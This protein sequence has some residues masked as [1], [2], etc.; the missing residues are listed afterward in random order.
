MTAVIQVRERLKESVQSSRPVSAATLDSP[1]AEELERAHRR[2]KHL[3]VLCVCMYVVCVLCVCV[4]IG[5]IFV[6]GQNMHFV[7]LCRPRLSDSLTRTLTP[8][9]APSLARSRALS[10]AH[11]H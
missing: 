5:F 9:L 10:L 6:S 4:Q 11:T 7:D 2:I 1:T 3:E 8:T